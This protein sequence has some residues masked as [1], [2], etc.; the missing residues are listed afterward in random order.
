MS[1]LTLIRSLMIPMLQKKPDILKTVKNVNFV[2]FY[3][4][5]LWYA[6]HYTPMHILLGNDTQKRIVSNPTG[7]HILSIYVHTFVSAHSHPHWNKA[8]PIA[9]SSVPFYIIL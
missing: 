1:V 9:I 3:V 7:N 5:Y 2:L 8:Q 6:L 4:S